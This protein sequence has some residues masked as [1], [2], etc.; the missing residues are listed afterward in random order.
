MFYDLCNL[1]CIPQKSLTLTFP[2]CL[3]ENLMASFILGYFDGD[4]CVWNGKRKKM[5]VK[6][7]SKK[8]GYRERIVHNVKFTFTGNSVFIQGL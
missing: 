6:D 4:G 3:P 7:S 8:N 2:T 1:G 5:L